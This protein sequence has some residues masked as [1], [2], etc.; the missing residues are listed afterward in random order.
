[1]KH[2]LFLFSLIVCLLVTGLV[3]RAGAEPADN[4]DKTLS[5]YFFV[6]GADPAVD[7]L[8]LQDT[9]VEVSIAGV[10]AD[11]TVRQIYENQGSRPIHARYVFPASTRAAVYGMT[12]TVGNQRVVAKIEERQRAK[13]DFD[14]AKEEGKSASLLEQDRPN[15]FSMNVANIMPRDTIAVELKYTELLVPAEGTY[16]LVYPTVVGSRYSTKEK[17]GAASHD[18]FVETPYLH[19][20]DSAKNEF[21]L[22]AK[23]STGVPLQDVACATHQVLTRRDGPTR[24]EV[25][26]SPSEIFAGNRD[27]ILR[28]RLAGN[29]VSTG[30]LL[31]QGTN[32]NFFLMMA[33]PPRSIAADDVPPREYIFVLDVSGSMNGFPLD[34]A[35]KLMRDLVHVVRPTDTFNVILFADGS[36]TLAPASLT[37]STENLERAVRFI[38]PQPGGG[39]TELLAALKRAVALPRTAPNVARTVVLLTDGYIDAEKET[40][41][42]IRDHLDEAS[43]FSFGIGSSVNR[44]LIEGVARA[45]RGEPF[46]VTRPE[47]SAKAAA[48]FRRYIQSPVLTGVRVAFRG[49]ETYDVEPTKIPDLFAERP[50]V[51]FGKWRGKPEGTIDVSGTSGKDV[52]RTSVQVG[53]AT[54][55]EQHRS[56]SYLWARARL[57]NLFDDGGEGNKDSVAEITA[58]G[59]GYS[60]LTPYTSFVAVHEV[61]R[62]EDGHAENV[63]QPLPLPLGVS[64]LAVGGS[65]VATGAEP[66]LYFIGAAL[67]LVLALRR[68]LDMGPRRTLGKAA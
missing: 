19:Q 20:G 12:M 27:F 15:V 6:E 68:A 37:A 36:R 46:V 9:R 30:L 38:G 24:A 31:Y 60:L 26:L 13:R 43:F 66:E 53:E 50:I 52:Y 14:K 2:S 35:K 41:R 23:L 29:Q 40:F 51:V 34:T 10:I 67:L 63:D 1:M 16:E 47:E 22:T 7:K 42:Y 44:F 11:V 18:R 62:N 48:K 58:I 61:V 4:T 8:P 65:S 57:A 64:D 17:S 32:E 25:T 54:P 3:R 49:F 56:L 21:H 33:E 5:P 59:L 55:E 39:G 45:G 28:Y